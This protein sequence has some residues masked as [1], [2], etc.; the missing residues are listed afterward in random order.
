MS[1]QASLGGGKEGAMGFSMGAWERTTV[2][3]VMQV[4]RIRAFDHEQVQKKT[5]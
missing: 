4:F 1:L 5:G 2:L 3:G